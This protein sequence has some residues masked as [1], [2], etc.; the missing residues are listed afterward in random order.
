MP[1]LAAGFESLG[2][3]VTFILA[4]SL[5]IFVHELGHF[6]VAKLCGIKVL[7]FS[8]FM[9]PR[10][11]G[12]KIGE[13]DYCVGATP[14]GGYVSMLGGEGGDE[15]DEAGGE[16]GETVAG[17]PRAFVNRPI[18]QRAAV[19]SAGVVMNLIFA[20]VLFIIVFRTG[21]NSLAPEVG[22]LAADG[23]AARQADA[24][25]AS[26]RPG[27]VILAVN[28][29]AVADFLEIKVETALTDSDKPLDLTVRRAGSGKTEKVTIRRGDKP[30]TAAAATGTAGAGKPG[31]GGRGPGGPAIG[32]APAT[33]LTIRPQPV[34]DGPALPGEPAAP[35]VAVGDTV[36]GY[37]AGA[38]GDGKFTPVARFDEL[39]DAFALHAG[40]PFAL[41]VRSASGNERDVPATPHVEHD[42]MAGAGRFLL[43]GLAPRVRVTQVFAGSPADRAGLRAGDV[44]VAVS[45]GEAAVPL[46]GELEI[47]KVIAEASAA[48]RGVT[49]RVLRDADGDGGSAGTESDVFVVP[50]PRGWERASAIGIAF[51]ASDTPH[52]VVG[53]VATACGFTDASL[54]VMKA[55]GVPEAVADKIAAMKV[56]RFATAEEAETALA[57]ALGK[58][59][60]AAHRTAILAAMDRSRAAR[61][62]LAKGD[63]IVSLDGKPVASWDELARVVARTARGVPAGPRDA[64]G[65]VKGKSVAIRYERPAADGG[66]PKAIDSTVEILPF[67]YEIEHL[68]VNVGL[69][70]APK[71]V[72]LQAE[73]VPQAIAMGLDK[74]WYMVKQVYLTLSQMLRG[75]L[76]AENLSGPLGIVAVGAQ[77]AE[78]DPLQMWY[79]LAA[80]N[81]NLAV[82]NFLPIPVLDGG[83]IVLLLAEKLRGR[84]VS[85]RLRENITIVGLVLLLSI[86]VFVTFNDLSRMFGAK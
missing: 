35:E 51:A 56:R 2:A 10:L 75:R 63:R 27:D 11:F 45:G 16:G 68:P 84:P 9:P 34:R 66:K 74:T 6:V 80:I 23:N 85:A 52:F 38:A 65:R 36:I 86:F 48:G 31:K 15:A 24:G 33:D 39:Q 13:T 77:V 59:E 46:P 8:I 25:E 14:L 78:R 71:Q 76:G 17:N 70:W 67:A 7:R 69:R 83:H 19:L 26:L 64:A 40:E 61:A 53:S 41:R 62:G 28:G 12:I 42:E 43:D 30:D 72:T 32:F 54:A 4:F 3:L 29:T 81:V 21:L 58:E 18:W 5:V 49:L 73:T 22:R 1:V 20:F 44:L 82:L 60:L 55:A 57:A 47:R 79:L 50:E 37:T